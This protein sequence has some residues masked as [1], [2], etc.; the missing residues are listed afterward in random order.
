MNESRQSI[1]P[2]NIGILDKFIRTLVISG[3]DYLSAA[4]QVEPH[5]VSSIGRKERG[6]DEYKRSNDYP[7]VHVPSYWSSLEI[8]DMLNNFNYNHCS[9]SRTLKDSAEFVLD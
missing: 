2:S 3:A 9:I 1:L 5:S 8:T 7:G 6:F 4:K